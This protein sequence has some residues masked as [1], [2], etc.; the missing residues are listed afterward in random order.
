MLE[1]LTHFDTWAGRFNLP[2]RKEDLLNSF[3]K[4]GINLEY[5]GI[6]TSLLSGSPSKESLSLP[7][8]R[9]KIEAIYQRVLNHLE[10]I[11]AASDNSNL[12][13]CE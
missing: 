7:S 3:K 11:V 5:G 2:K 10:G 9:K 1:V 12:F 4:H 13:P 6:I 8:E